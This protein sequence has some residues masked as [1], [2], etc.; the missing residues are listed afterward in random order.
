MK[1]KN[2]NNQPYL[3]ILIILILLGFGYYK[4]QLNKEKLSDFSIANGKIVE[5][6]QRF[7]RGYFIKYNYKILGK[8][9]FNNQ[10]LTI[11]KELVTV[12]DI[13][14]VKYSVKDKTVSELNFKKRI[15]N[16]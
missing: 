14:E 10:K 5:I 9:Y 13:F 8:N 7:Q 1:L 16:E 15:K 12:G 2:K 4:S 6:E 11:K 3:I